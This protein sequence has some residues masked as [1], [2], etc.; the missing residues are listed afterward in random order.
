MRRF[1]VIWTLAHLPLHPLISPCSLAGAFPFPQTWH[2][3]TS[4]S[5]SLH[6]SQTSFLP[7]VL[8]PTQASYLSLG[9]A[10]SESISLASILCP[11]KPTIVLINLALLQFYIIYGIIWSVS[12]FLSRQY[13]CLLNVPILN[14]VPSTK[15][16]FGSEYISVERMRP[17]QPC[18]FSSP[19]QLCLPSAWRNRL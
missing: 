12:A 14:T 5:L 15:Y 7:V 9:V 13:L 4:C 17:G 3:P 19:S 1:S 2:I 16:I 8:I 6:H 18:V 10:F 11:H